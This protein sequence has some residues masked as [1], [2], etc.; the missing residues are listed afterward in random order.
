MT[1]T[2]DPLREAHRLLGARL[3][4]M[5]L[6]PG[7][8]ALPSEVVA[9]DK[10][11]LDGVVIGR[12]QAQ[13]APA[14]D[15]ADC[16]GDHPSGHP[17]HTPPDPLHEAYLTDEDDFEIDGPDPLLEMAAKARAICR[18]P[19]GHDA[20]PTPALD[21]MCP[22]CGLSATRIGEIH[23]NAQEAKGR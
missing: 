6:E 3:D 8:P 17:W 2:P 9:Y 4:S 18:K 7:R 12:E 14:L 1:P 15:C 10:G 21:R 19:K 5:V 23:I 22:D 13:P 11:F 20:Q 16:G